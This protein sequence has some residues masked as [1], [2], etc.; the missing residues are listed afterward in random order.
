M[1]WN[2]ECLHAGIAAQ[3]S[4]AVKS[5]LY[6]RGNHFASAPYVLLVFVIIT[7]QEVRSSLKNLVH[8]ARLHVFPFHVSAPKGVAPYCTNN[9][10]ISHPLGF[11][12]QRCSNV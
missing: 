10:S 1:R 6:T 4:V 2:Q 11:G 5:C 8:L 3:F 12:W 9:A 7:N